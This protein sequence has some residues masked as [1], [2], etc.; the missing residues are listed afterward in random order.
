MLRGQR[1]RSILSLWRQG[2]KQ[3]PLGLTP[4]QSLHSHCWKQTG[5]SSHSLCSPS[6][7]YLSI[8]ITRGGQWYEILS[9]RNFQNVSFSDDPSLR[10]LIIKNEQMS[11]ECSIQSGGINILVF[12]LRSPN[13]EP[14]QCTKRSA[15]QYERLLLVSD[16][17]SLQYI[18][19]W[20]GEIIGTGLDHL[21]LFWQALWSSL[22]WTL[23]LDSC[24]QLVQRLKQTGLVPEEWVPVSEDWPLVFAQSWAELSF[25]Q[26]CVISRSFVMSMRDTLIPTGWFS[27]PAA[28][29][30]FLSAHQ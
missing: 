5:L 8:S 14:N 27:L 18:Y 30:L 11:L 10:L 12:E 1:V 25:S 19:S 24:S 3:Q 26:M 22:I 28:N 13:T 9:T 6:P 16:K 29:L 4:E 20:Y 15:Y 7:D 23:L 17:L 2:H 21:A